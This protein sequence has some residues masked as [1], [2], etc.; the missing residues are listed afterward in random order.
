M[1]APFISN[2][3]AIIFNKSITEGV[4]PDSLK[5]AR[6]SPIHKKGEITDPSNYRPISVL[7]LINKVFE[8]LFIRDH[9]V[10]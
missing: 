4:F 9:I 2:I 1:C 5:I 10:T 7:S 8:K 6:V 3:L